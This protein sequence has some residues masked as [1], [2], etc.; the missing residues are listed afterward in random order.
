MAVFVS[1]TETYAMSTALSVIAGASCRF[2]RSFFTVKIR[3]V[4]NLACTAR[5]GRLKVVFNL[6]VTD[7]TRKEKTMALLSSYPF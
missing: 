7:W 1:N 3:I 6:L 2:E 4:M 5:T